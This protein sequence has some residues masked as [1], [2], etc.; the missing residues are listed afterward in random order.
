ML[1]RGAGGPEDQGIEAGRSPG[2]SCSEVCRCRRPLQ[3][4]G[5]GK[6]SPAL[7]WVR[8]S[9][10]DVRS[11]GDEGLVFRAG[12][13]SDCPRWWQHADAWT[14]FVP[15][16]VALTHVCSVIHTG[17]RFH[18]GLSKGGTRYS[19][20]APRVRGSVSPRG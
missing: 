19:P 16:D 5:L 14:G 1:G 12:L 4:T 8:P 6:P 7:M 3:V 18:V 10:C 2:P 11:E 20:G 15:R 13:A 9:S 17:P